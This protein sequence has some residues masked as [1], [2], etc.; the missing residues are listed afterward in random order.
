MQRLF[1][2]AILTAALSAPALAQTTP[3]WEY[4]QYTVTTSSAGSLNAWNERARV[5]FV[6]SGFAD[7]LKE[8]GAQPAQ[9]GE[10]NLLT[11][12]NWAG[13]NGWELFSSE[14]RTTTITTS[15]YLF[16]RSRR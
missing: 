13:A 2:L 14:T 7:F 9:Q 12:L 8:T 1:T 4:A 5:F 10:P 15:T 16:K 3:A 11:V 6:T